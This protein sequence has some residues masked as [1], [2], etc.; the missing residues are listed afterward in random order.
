MM[1]IKG[2][3]FDWAGTI[4]D[5]GSLAPMGAFVTLFARHG[6]AISIAQ[7]RVPMGL[8]KIDHI[9]ALGR[10]A[11]VAEPW[12]K[13]FGR[14]FDDT[15][16]HQLLHEFEPMSAQ[17]AIDHW[18]FIPGFLP[19]YKALKSQGMAFAT[20]TGY[21]RTIMTPLIAHALAQGFEPA[22]VVCC[23]D[24]ERSRPD[25][26]GMANC[27]DAMHLQGHAHQVIKVDDTAPG[28]AEGLAAGC[29]TVGVTASGN[30]LGWSLDQWQSATDTERA[31]ALQPG[32][33]ALLAAGAHVLIESVAQLPL[34]IERIEQRIAQG[35]M[36]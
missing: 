22:L 16:A 33:Q 35:E 26:M 31:T 19:V 23:D 20:T 13:L 21:T 28:L 27:L 6:I 24:V 34:A 10:M 7:A 14:P 32:S 3:V 17:A 18:D 2:I 9:W 36:P 11:A 15:D 1:K 5:F 8:P 30:A 4:V 25:P 12:Q 29:W